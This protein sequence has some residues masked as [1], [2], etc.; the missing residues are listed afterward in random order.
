MP[1]SKNPFD[2]SAM[3]DAM[4]AQAQQIWLAGLG[5]FSKAQQDGAKAFEKLVSDGISMQRKAQ[6][7]A[8]EKI[9]EA[10]ERAQQAAEQFKER[11]SGQWGKFE[12]IFEERVAK[13][14]HRMG[15]PSV[16]DL[17]ALQARVEALEAQLGGTPANSA[18][19]TS[20]RASR[21]T[22]PARK[23]AAQRAP[24]KTAARKAA[25]KKK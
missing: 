12:G 16:M 20:A 6:E 1:N 9:A 19:K 8:E 24:T 22:S 18:S 2:P 5:A 17:Q 14:L 11:A 23:T 15:M 4:K 10:T 7:T 3:T 21:A 13:A 25:A